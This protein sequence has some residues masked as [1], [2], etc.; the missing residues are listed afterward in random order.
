MIFQVHNGKIYND[1]RITEDMVG[2]KLGEFSACVALSKICIAADVLQD[3]KALHLQAL[4]EQVNAHFKV[5]LSHI[6]AFH[7]FLCTKFQSQRGTFGNL[8]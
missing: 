2:H 4:Q 5:D 6:L 3:E 8:I 1:V 7:G